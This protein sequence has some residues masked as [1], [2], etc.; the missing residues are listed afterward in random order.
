MNKKYVKLIQLLVVCTILIIATGWYA[1]KTSKDKQKDLTFMEFMGFSPLPSF[2]SI[3]VGMS[4]GLVFG[5]IDNA[6]LFF[7]MDALDPFLP[8]NN[9]IAAGLGNTF[10]DGVGAFMGTFCGIII[11]NLTGVNSYPILSEAIGMIV[12]CLIG[13]YL[14]A[15]I[16]GVK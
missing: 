7:G 5:F 3:L 9:L 2:K 8:K 10:S 6:G 12:G 14:P 15:A 16:L 11:S 13:V 4:S 1:Y